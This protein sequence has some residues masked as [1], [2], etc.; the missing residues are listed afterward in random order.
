[1]P[2]GKTLRLHPWSWPQ[3]PGESLAL[4]CDHAV[5]GESGRPREEVRCRDTNHSDSQLDPMGKFHLQI[6]GMTLAPG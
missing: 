5:P 2:G 6:P 4:T 1:M 3:V